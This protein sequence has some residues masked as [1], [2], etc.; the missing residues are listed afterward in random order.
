MPTAG[1]VFVLLFWDKVSIAQTGLELALGSRQA[2]NLHFHCLL[3]AE[4]SYTAA[5]LIAFIL[6]N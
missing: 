1:Y 3:I 2:L 6:H 5:G 4:I